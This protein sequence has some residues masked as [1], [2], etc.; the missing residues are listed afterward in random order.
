MAKEGETLVLLDGTEAKLNADTLV[1]A[2]HNKAL[3]MAG[4]FGGEH[5]GVNDET[6]KRSVGVRFL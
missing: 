6:Q 5:S 1:I 2:D 3:A 4:I